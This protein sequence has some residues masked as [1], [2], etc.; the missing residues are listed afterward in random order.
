MSLKDKYEG[1]KSAAFIESLKH[2]YL[3][4]KICVLP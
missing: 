1:K 2:T 3:Q 4:L